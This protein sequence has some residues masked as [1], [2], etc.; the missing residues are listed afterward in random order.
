M[1]IPEI[2]AIN[3][4][5]VPLL[6]TTRPGASLAAPATDDREELSR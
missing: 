5:R 4:E 6:H 2:P 1:G 3:V